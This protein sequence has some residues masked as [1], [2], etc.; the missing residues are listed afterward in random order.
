[1]PCVS[2]I[3]NAGGEGRSFGIKILHLIPGGAQGKSGWSCAVESFKHRPCLIRQKL[4]ISLSCLRQETLLSDPD[5]F[6]FAYRIKYKIV[7]TDIEEKNYW[8]YKCRP[9]T[10][11]LRSL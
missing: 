4:L 8:F 3:N 5:L 1:M 10:A 6:C 9:L 11:S 2:Q 7:E